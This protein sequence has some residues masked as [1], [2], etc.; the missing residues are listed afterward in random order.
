MSLTEKVIAEIRE[1]IRTGE[2]QPGSKLPP[3]QQLAARLG[4]G[5][6][7]LRE[8]VQVLAASRVL[9]VR[10]GSGTYVTTLEPR[11][12]LEGVGHAVELIRADDLLELT[13]VRRLF[14]PVATALAA[15]RITPDQLL[16]VQA[17]LEAMHEAANDVEQ[18]NRHDAAF[19]REVIA[20]TG[21]ETLSTLLEG[22]SS[23]TIRSRVWR[24]LVDAESTWRTLAD[25]QEI[26]AAL[27]VGDPALAQAA[28][29]MH[30]HNTERWLRNHL[31]D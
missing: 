3:E 27:A 7:L 1:L 31:P 26:Y 30:V 13:E 23:R 9:E 17:H 14:E 8:A 29:L 15:V 5:R 11:L 6:N 24:G 4:V 16:R 28:A 20:A 10:R 19:H 25:H 21:N 2:L 18:L 22:I 12:L